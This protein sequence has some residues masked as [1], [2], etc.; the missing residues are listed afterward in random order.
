MGVHAREHAVEK[1][2]A[3]ICADTHSRAFEFARAYHSHTRKKGML[4]RSRIVWFLPQAVQWLTGPGICSV[5]VACIPSPP[6]RPPLYRL[7]RPFDDFIVKAMWAINSQVAARQFF[8]EIPRILMATNKVYS[9]DPNEI[10]FTELK[11]GWNYSGP[12]KRLLISYWFYY[13]FNL[14]L[15][16]K[17]IGVSIQGGW[18]GLAHFRWL[19]V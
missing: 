8:S 9:D 10:P 6:A 5:G 3:K 13:I 2:D 11:S 19:S 18:F 15:V 17:R 12:P 14:I 1:Y 4:P 7:S 16:G